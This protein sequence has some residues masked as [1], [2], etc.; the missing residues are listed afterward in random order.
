MAPWSIESLLA[1]EKLAGA[2]ISVMASNNHTVKPLDAQ[3]I[4]ETARITGA[5]V[6]AEEHQVAGGMGSAVP[7]LP[8][9]SRRFSR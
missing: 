5:V 2:G 4:L 9:R 3:A 6:T 8:P 1:A 7:E